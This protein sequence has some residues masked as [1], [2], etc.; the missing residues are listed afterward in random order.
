MANLIIGLCEAN[1][2]KRYLHAEDVLSK[3]H[4]ARN[5]HDYVNEQPTRCNYGDRTL[6]LH[7]SWSRHSRD[8][9]KLRVKYSAGSSAREL[10]T[11]GRTRPH[12]RVTINV[13]ERGAQPSLPVTTVAARSARPR[14]RIS[15]FTWDIPVL[16]Q[17][18][19]ACECVHTGS[20]G[21]IGSCAFRNV[22][23]TLHDVHFSTPAF[24][25]PRR[26]RRDEVSK[27]WRVYSLNTPQGKLMTVSLETRF[28]LLV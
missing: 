13:S 19:I 27:M 9:E 10:L 16:W 24:T 1:L 6:R 11:S 25:R 17:E 2:R 15:G 5:P 22:R 18:I 3:Q 21:H 7:A 28:H 20:T 26:R 23:F 4:A 12:F 14:P 8:G